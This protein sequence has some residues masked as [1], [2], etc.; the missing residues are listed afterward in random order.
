[1]AIRHN[2]LGKKI[3]EITIMT[4]NSKLGKQLE[5]LTRDYYKSKTELEAAEKS[6][7]LKRDKLKEMGINPTPAEHCRGGKMTFEELVAQESHLDYYISGN[8]R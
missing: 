5:D 8:R 4:A 3:Q 1:M 6:H 2:K 7:N